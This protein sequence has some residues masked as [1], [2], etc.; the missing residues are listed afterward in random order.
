[1]V[2]IKPRPLYPR[3]ITPVLIGGWVGPRAGRVFLWKRRESL[4]PARV[5]V[6][7]DIS[8]LRHSVQ[9]LLDGCN[10]DMILSLFGLYSA[11][12]IFLSLSSDR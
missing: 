8:K 2:I 1:V 5:M 10:A 4:A 9:K 11:G 3:D 6:I 12:Q 7:S